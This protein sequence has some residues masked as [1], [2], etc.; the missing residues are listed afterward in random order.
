[1]EA[2]H[3]KD[4]LC[5]L[6]HFLNKDYC[7]T[8]QNASVLSISLNHTCTVTVHLTTGFSHLNVIKTSGKIIAS[9][10]YMCVRLESVCARDGVCVCVWEVMASKAK[11]WKHIIDSCNLSSI[12]SL[13]LSLSQRVSHNSLLS[14]TTPHPPFLPSFLFNHSL[15]LS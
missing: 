4:L 6:L 2:K 10:V 8:S 12:R 1:M 9:G 7:W 3:K 5:A 14:R 13:L 15:T 11:K